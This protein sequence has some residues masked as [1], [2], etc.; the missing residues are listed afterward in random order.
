MACGLVW[1]ALLDSSA[2]LYVYTHK[3]MA[4]LAPPFTVVFLFSLVFVAGALRHACVYVWHVWMVW[5]DGMHAG[6]VCGGGAVAARQPRMVPL[7]PLPPVAP[8]FVPPHSKPTPR[9]VHSK[10]PPSPARTGG[11]NGGGLARPCLPTES[12][13]R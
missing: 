8:S 6:R 5:M 11:A 2:G 13:E 4:Y 1:I 7:S 12:A 9:H 3:L 10:P